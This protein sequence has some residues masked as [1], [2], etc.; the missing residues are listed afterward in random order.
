MNICKLI[1]AL[2]ACVALVAP[3]AKADLINHQYDD[4]VG[5]VLLGPPD[6]FSV[7]G[8]IDM[9]WGN[10]F[11]TSAPVEALTHI[12]F[13][14][15]GLSAGGLVSVWIFDDPDD[16]AN[17]LNAQPV[18]STTTTAANLVFDFNQLDI[19]PTQVAGGFFVAVGHLAEL[20]TDDEG[21]P[22]YPAPARFDP[23]ARA[24]R[25]WF[26]YDSDIPETDLAGSGY[27]QR[28]D[29]PSV[30]IHGAFSI[31]AQGVAVPEPLSLGLLAAGGVVLLRR[32][33]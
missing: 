11:Y 29:S 25:S 24:D 5:N 2:A 16:D 21:D 19:P 4:G 7:Y 9:L 23:D 14:V 33:R 32:L 13:G 28:M 17:P 3:A 8:D 10:Y 22:D 26:F 20:T 31:R 15:G 12:E 18:F 1:A 6:S 27:Y 30:P